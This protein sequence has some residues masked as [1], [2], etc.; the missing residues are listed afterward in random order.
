MWVVVQVGVVAKTSPDAGG[1]IGKPLEEVQK[2]VLANGDQI[3]PLAS[4][5]HTC[6]DSDHDTCLACQE[7][8]LGFYDPKTYR[9]ERY[10]K[11]T[12]RSAKANSGS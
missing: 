3:Y 7:G 9:I 10:K 6:V 4:S 11:D 8:N 12:A 1:L 2:L 5:W